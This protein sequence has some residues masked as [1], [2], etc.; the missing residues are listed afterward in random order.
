[1]VAGHD[2]GGRVAYRLALDHPEAVSA[3]VPVDIIPTGEVWRR[4]N[5]ELGRQDL[6]L[7]LPGAAP[8]AARAP[9]RQGPGLL[10]RAHAGELGRSARPV[11]VFAPEALAS[12]RAL[13][14]EP[15]RMHAVCEDYRAGATID[16]RLDDADMAAGRR[17]ACPTFSSGPTTTSAAA[18]RSIVWRLW[19]SATL[20]GAAVES[21]HYQ[22]EENP[23]D[24]LAALIPFLSPGSAHRK[25]ARDPDRL[26]RMAGTRRQRYCAGIHSTPPLPT[27][28]MTEVM[29]RPARPCRCASRPCPPR[30]RRSRWRWAA[31]ARAGL[32]TSSCWRCS[33]SSAS[34]PTSLPARRSAPCSARPTPRASRPRLIRAHT[35]EV[36]SQRLGLA[37]YLLSAR[38]EPVQVPQLP[39]DPLL[40]AEA[41]DCC[42]T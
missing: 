16:R 4:A 37:R 5:A 10:R 18:R 39:A 30:G 3:L 1:M 13:L 34:S 20:S 8:S 21:G 27:A 32:R 28:G 15:A 31:A 24:T 36:L 29:N 17:I 7:V 12:Y 22:A 26:Q 19:C 6:P 41:R 35:E 23:K 38:S 33:T 11:A 14:E 2:R 25:D 40:A 42:S 9:D